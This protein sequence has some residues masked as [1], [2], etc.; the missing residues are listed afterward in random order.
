MAASVLLAR[1]SSRMADEASTAGFGTPLTTLRTP[2]PLRLRIF[3]GD[4][5]DLFDPRDWPDPADY[6]HRVY[7]DERATAWAIVDAIDYE[8]AVQWRW[9]IKWSRGGRKFYLRRAGSDRTGAC[10]VQRTI[11]LHVEIMKRTG[12]APPSPAHTMVDHRNGDAMFCRRRNLRWA[13][14]SMNRTG[15]DR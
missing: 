8:W 1:S 14:P 10:R 3:S 2:E 15:L 4:K 7:A 11:W 13:T 6:E 9:S 5:P 12:I